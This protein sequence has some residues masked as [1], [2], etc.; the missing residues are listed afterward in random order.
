MWDWRITYSNGTETCNLRG[1]TPSDEQ[2]WL[3]LH[4]Q[5]LAAMQIKDANPVT[6]VDD[7]RRVE[8]DS[9]RRHAEKSR[10]VKK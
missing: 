1:T 8:A 10:K 3:T 6:S 5:I 4:A 2:E 9:V 7:L